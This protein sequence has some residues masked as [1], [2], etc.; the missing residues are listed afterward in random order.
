MPSGRRT[1]QSVLVLGD[2]IVDVIGRVKAWPQPGDDCL[3]PRLEMHCGG[4][5]ANCA[6]ALARWGMWPRLL[7]CV[8]RDNFGEYLLHMLRRAR[9]DVR[10]VQRSAKAMTG[11]LYV[12]VTPD[13]QRTFFGSRAANGLVRRVAQGSAFYR[14]AAGAHVVGY[15]FLNPAAEKAARQLMRT[16]RARGGWIAL[17]V[18]ALPSQQIPRKILQLCRNVDILFVNQDEAAALTGIRDPRKAF[19]RLQKTGAR[20]VVMKLGKRGCLLVED[21][22]LLEV[23][24][25]VVR[26]VDSTG[27]GDA[28]VAAFL[29]GRM[30]GWPLAESALA[31]NAAGA[32][33]ASVVGAGA[34]LPGAREV[35]ALLRH[36]RYGGKWDAVRRNILERLRIVS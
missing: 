27:A 26:A 16:I 18:G 35:A 20:Q 10:W 5:A 2:I 1:G 9:V 7:G 12:N 23:P 29:Q 32:L 4:V 19:A 28:F 15:N 14:G 22:T 8:G 24:S 11:L 30:R 33:A 17:D 3:A 36:E 31:A 34:N 13:G 25:C 6:F 21:A